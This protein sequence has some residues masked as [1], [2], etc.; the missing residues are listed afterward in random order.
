MLTRPFKHR[1]A[2]AAA[3]ASTLERHSTEQAGETG[4]PEAALLQNI[5]CYCGDTS[6]VVEFV[7]GM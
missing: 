6:D 7:P 2:S 4:Q 1:H 5:T 3:S